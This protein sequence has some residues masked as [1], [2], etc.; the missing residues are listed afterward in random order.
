MFI[1]ITIVLLVI[2]FFNLGLFYKED[3]A[4]DKLSFSKP[5]KGGE[6][7]EYRGGNKKGVLFIHGYPGSPK[8]FYMARELAIKSGYDVFSPRLPGFSSTKEEF[9]KT[10]FSMWFNFIKKYYLNL[11]EE[12]ESIYVVGHSMGGALTLKLCEELYRE[13]E[14]LPTAIAVV[15]A[16]IF[17]N[18]L[19]RGVKLS[20]LLKIVRTIGLFTDYIPSNKPIKSKDL[21]QDGD[22]EWIGYR[23]IF[24]KQT[25]SLKIGLKNV[26]KNL[27]KV[28]TPCFLSHG[29]GD[30]TVPFKNLDYISGRINSSERVIKIFNLDNW[31]HSKHSLFIYKTV[32]GPLWSS[33]DTFFKSLKK[34]P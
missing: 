18:N 10:N 20:F 1:V 23:G 15:S 7:F 26:G 32:V 25:F 28:K 2:I 16:P 33:I 27:Y 29:E 6:P 9:I 21:D 22:S 24:P 17:L 5:L 11:R 34:S 3:N 14:L 13:K 8:M 19:K 30:R 31:K 4:Y 12:Y